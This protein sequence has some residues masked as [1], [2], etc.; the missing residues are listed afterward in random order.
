MKKL[1]YFLF[2]FSFFVL[3]FSIGGFF[4]AHKPIQTNTFYASVNV[5]DGIGFDINSTAL[6][7]GNVVKGGSSNRNINLLN[8]YPFPV[9]AVIRVDGDISP[10]LN[11]ED[12]VGIKSNESKKLSFNVI[13]PVSYDENFYSGNVTVELYRR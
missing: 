4:F 6:T 7:F 11:Y 10:L 2:V 13:A 9:V 1:S 12:A 8:D 3:L 5:T